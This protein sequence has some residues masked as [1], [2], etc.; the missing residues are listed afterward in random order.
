[1]TTMRD[2]RGLASV[3]IGLAETDDQVVRLPD[4]RP[5]DSA[6]VATEL[7]GEPDA[8]LSTGSR[9]GTESGLASVAP[10]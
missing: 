9:V 3:R 1:M 10:P 5:V 2:V 7:A 4:H 8:T 6:Y